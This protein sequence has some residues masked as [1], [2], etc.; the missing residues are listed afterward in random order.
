MTF[1][2][3]EQ[4]CRRILF[5]YIDEEKIKLEKPKELADLALPCFLVSKHPNEFAFQL[6]E[7]IEKKLTPKSLILKVKAIGPYLNFYINYSVFNK[8]VIKDALDKKYGSKKSLGKRIV[9]DYSS[10]NIAKPMNI[11]HLRSTIIGQSLYNILSYQGY[12]CIGDNHLGDWGTQFGKLICA[13]KRWGNARDIKAKGIEE[14]LRLYVKFHEEAEKE[15]SGIVNTTEQEKTEKISL[16]DEARKNVFSLENEARSWFKKLEDGNKEAKKIWNLFYKISR[17]E[18]SKT[19]KRLGI[20]FDY[21]LGESFYVKETKKL[22][23]ELLSKN[24]AKKEQ[25]AVIIPG[26]QPPLIIQ[27]SD[28]ATTYG[29]RELATIKYRISKFKPEKIIWVTG[30]E[31][32][33][34]F[35]QVFDACDKIF[36]DHPQLIHV[37]FGLVSLPEGRLSTREGRVIFLDDVINQTVD[38]AKKTIEEK[39]PTLKNKEKVAEK[40]ALG[41]IKYNDLS[42]DR[43]KNIAFD[44]DEMLRFEGDTGPYLQY[45]YAR[46]CSITKKSKYSGKTFNANILNKES[47]TRIIKK[48]SLFPLAIE[49]A[50]INYKPHVVANYLFELA[51]LFNEF[52]HSL[53][54]IGS[55]YEKER[56]ALTKAFIN[57][58]KIGLGL[59]GI[60]AVEEM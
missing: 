23:Y 31:Q 56:I 14:M 43:I 22:I 24:I 13:Y 21:T 1:N 17:N 60:E 44:W 3:F 59:L 2:K 26:F 51:T 19:Y 36:Q 7:K 42:R 49:N 55:K 40:V 47:E 16:D 54:V 25:G 4:E 50:A 15:N 5:N 37:D 58:M 20:K 35:Q 10:P 8:I 11:G 28:E 29:A 18:F 39:N 53:Q 12:R 9:I 46:A 57:V 30:N 32:R 45:T 38:L 6:Q 27:K 34:Y 33:L 48:L 41:A 52:Y